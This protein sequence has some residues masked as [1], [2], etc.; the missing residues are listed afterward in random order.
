MALHT[1]VAVVLLALGV[2]EVEVTAFA[3]HFI[4]EL[5]LLA[6]PPTHKPALLWA[7]IG[8]ARKRRRKKKKLK[9]KSKKKRRRTHLTNWPKRSCKRRH[10]EIH[11]RK[12]ILHRVCNTNT[13]ETQ[14]SYFDF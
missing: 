10:I 12:P 3:G 6:K 2:R 13:V 1:R 11:R 4:D 14:S 5:A 7:S 8:F 9:K